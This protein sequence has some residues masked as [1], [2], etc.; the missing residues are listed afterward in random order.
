[1]RELFLF[2][3]VIIL[4]TP[5]C[6]VGSDIN[7]EE[8]TLATTTSMRDSG[9][10]E[11]LLPQFTTSTG[12]ELRYVAVG[13]GAALNLGESGDADVLIV[14]SPKMEE[15][16]ISLGKGIERTPFTWNKFIII[17]PSNDPANISKTT[18][19][20]EA[21]KRIHA[22]KSCFVSRG[23]ES[24]THSKEI[25]LWDIANITPKGD[26]YLSIGQGMGAAI[27][28]AY[29]KDCYTLSDRGTFLHRDDTN[30]KS[31]NFNSEEL[32]NIYSI[33]I[34]DNPMKEQSKILQEYLNSDGQDVIRNYTV[35]G[36]I[37]FNPISSL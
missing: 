27:T 32:V 24:G 35:N 12:I 11:Y 13:T 25:E 31:Y 15:E 1:L 21:L 4:L 19:V 16:F 29:Q 36:E 2:T 6:I 37:L 34:L 10:L 9:L 18:D 33:I 3:I 20:F 28:M 14:H 26:W 8:F 23:D 7:N 22:T 17:G 5:G 30:L